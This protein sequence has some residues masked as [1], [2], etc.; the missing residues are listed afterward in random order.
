MADD[1]TPSQSVFRYARQKWKD[2]VAANWQTQNWNMW[3]E[4]NTTLNPDWQD[5][6]F[7]KEVGRCENAAPAVD[8]ETG[9]YRDDG[10]QICQN[11]YGVYC[12][13]KYKGYHRYAMCSIMTHM[14][15]ESGVSGGAWEG[16]YHPYRTYVDDDGSYVFDPEVSSVSLAGSTW[17]SG[18]ALGGSMIPGRTI[19]QTP[20]D[21]SA[22]QAKV[23]PAGSWVAVKHPTAFL[24]N[25]DTGT[26]QY[27]P[28]DWDMSTCVGWPG[29][30]GG[31]GLVQWTLWGKLPRLG[32]EAAVGGSKQW[33]LSPVLQLLV[34]E[35]ERYYSTVPVTPGQDYL[36]E[37]VSTQAALAGFQT[38]VGGPVNAYGSALPWSSPN[39][40]DY[41]GDGW[42]SWVNDKI[43]Q[44]E[45]DEG[46]T[47]TS[48]QKD[49]FRRQTGISLWDWCFEKYHYTLQRMLDLDMDETS[50]YVLAAIDYWDT[51]NQGDDYVF[52]I[53]HP[54]D[55]AFGDFEL[56]YLHLP[57]W[58]LKKAADRRKRGD[59]N[60]RTIL[61]R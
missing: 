37:W 40:T 47:F 11:L 35:R 7:Q 55:I 60:A 4:Y 43:A 8:P 1:W 21:G 30:G 2:R 48:E 6:W 9:P 38:Y 3:A 36:G 54:R 52:D 59:R 56:D 46:I 42:V 41:R 23:Q 22:Q 28:G 45:T 15:Q 17:F 10:Y 57:I 39:Q 50:L 13:L 58:L 25:Y 34:M 16:G 44:I 26:G 31:Y 51:L 14:I 61:L 12:W 5:V 19:Y 33:Q 24:W 27:S 49:W 53:P 29:N 32:E 18:S 20:P